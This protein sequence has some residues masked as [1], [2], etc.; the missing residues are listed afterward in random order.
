[1]SRAVYEHVS[2]VSTKVQ[3]CTY[4]ESVAANVVGTDT[5][6]RHFQVLDAVDVQSLVQDTMLDDVIAILWTHATSSKRVPGSLAVALDP[7]LDQ[8]DW[9]W[10]SKVT[11]S[12]SNATYCPPWCI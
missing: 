7:F 10:V 2:M 3:F 8:R 4:R 1:M 12:C 9:D 5:E 11:T 6:I